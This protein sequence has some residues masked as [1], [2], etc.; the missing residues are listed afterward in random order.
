MIGVVGLLAAAGGAGLAGLLLRPAFGRYGG[1]CE[2][3]AESPGSLTG[4]L[5]ALG[6]RVLAGWPSLRPA[7]RSAGRFLLCSEALAVGLGALALLAG[8]GWALGGVLALLPLGVLA[9]WLRAAQ[10]GRARR[11]RRSWETD[12]TAWLGALAMQVSAGRELRAALEATRE[13][14]LAGAAAEVADA[15]D[16]R[17]RMG[18][19]TAGA[20]ED[21]A[22]HAPDGSTAAFFS[23]LA[24][25]V[26]AGS[27]LGPVLHAEAERLRG[28]RRRRV[29]AWMEALPGRLTVYRALMLGA[30]ASP[31]VALAWALVGRLTTLL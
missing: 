17:H 31:M 12:V 23:R 4:L 26:R 21:V 27:P 1:W 14:G 9:A 6:A 8:I 7:A 13:G 19:D 15:L 20:L 16:T 30:A 11:Q 18:W 29:Q 5:A 22:R 25:S 24:T 28:D 2:Q 3:W 10:L